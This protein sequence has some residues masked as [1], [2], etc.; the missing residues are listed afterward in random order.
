MRTRTGVKR[1]EGGAVVAL[2]RRLNGV[3]RFLLML[4]L[5]LLA[6]I[7]DAAATAAVQTSLRSSSIDVANNWRFTPSSSSSVVADGPR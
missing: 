6:I 7:G 4:L 5:L 1:G 2:R 3:H